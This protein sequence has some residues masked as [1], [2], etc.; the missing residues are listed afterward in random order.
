MM[1]DYLAAYTI[2]LIF[3]ISIALLGGKSGR[4]WQHVTIGAI[5]CAHISYPILYCLK[6]IA[7]S[8][9]GCQCP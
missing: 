3:F 7:K 5:V 4:N 8:F 2:T 1:N 6:I 9:I